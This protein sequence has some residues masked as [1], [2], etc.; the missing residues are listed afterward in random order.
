MRLSDSE[1]SNALCGQKYCCLPSPDGTSPSVLNS[2]AD[3]LMT[4]I[5]PIFNLSLS[6]GLFPD[7]WKCSHI[8]PKL[9]RNLFKMLKQ[10]SHQGF[11][12]GKSTVT[13]SLE[14]A[15]HV[16]GSFEN[17]MQA[18]FIYTDFSKAVDK[19]NHGLLWV[20]ICYLKDRTQ[21]ILIRSEH[22]RGAI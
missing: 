3:V 10:L 11:V 16:F 18:N 21:R 1:V 17:G 19:V 14:F 4:P 13:N 22:G 2:C 6:S 9:L 20:K 7:I 5:K 8:L 15:R 12:D